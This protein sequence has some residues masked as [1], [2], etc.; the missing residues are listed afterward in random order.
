M[1]SSR[2]NNTHTWSGNAGRRPTV[3]KQ[4]RC[5]VTTLILLAGSVSQVFSVQTHISLRLLPHRRPCAASRSHTCA[6]VH[7][8]VAHLRGESVLFFSPTTHPPTHTLAYDLACWLGSDLSPW[9]AAVAREAPWWRGGQRVKIQRMSMKLG[10][11]HK[12]R[13]E[14]LTR[15][16]CRGVTVA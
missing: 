1:G 8:K 9:S 10:W 15:S 11:E 14:T 6:S 4:P 5:S 7:V 13:V 12:I 16:G 2:A 3:R